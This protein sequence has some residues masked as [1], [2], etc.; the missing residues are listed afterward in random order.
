MSNINKNTKQ[1]K[2]AFDAVLQHKAIV[3]ADGDLIGYMFQR[4]MKVKLP[5]G[6]TNLLTLDEEINLPLKGLWDLLP[7]II[8][9][10][11]NENKTCPEF[12][13]QSKPTQ[14]HSVESKLYR[15]LE[16]KMELY[17]VVGLLSTL[18][19][20]EIS[21]P[22]KAKKAGANSTVPAGK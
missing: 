22:V 14:R 15:F 2:S 5:D 4:A 12:A 20:S 17:N 1:N 16:S 19:K 6:S 9:L 7:T 21:K 18:K 8:K 13:T 11:D 3:S 10:L